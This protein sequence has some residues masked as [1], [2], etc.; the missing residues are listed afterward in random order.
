M[1]AIHPSVIEE[2][3]GK[4]IQDRMEMKFRDVVASVSDKDEEF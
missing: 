3:K 2:M 4:E 1:R